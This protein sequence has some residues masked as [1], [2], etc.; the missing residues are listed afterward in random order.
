M[1]MTKQKTRTEIIFL[2][3]EKGMSFIKLK[4]DKIN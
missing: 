2:V 1:S 4:W 3:K